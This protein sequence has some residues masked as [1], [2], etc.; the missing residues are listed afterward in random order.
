[1][2]LGGP[3]LFVP[4]TQEPRFAKAHSAGASQ[5]IVDWEDAV[6]PRDKDGARET[7]ARWLASSPPTWVRVN[8]ASTEWYESDVAALERLDGLAGVVVPKAEDPGVLQHVGDRLARPVMA[9]VE[10]ARGLDRARE[11]ART[12]AVVAIA[13][14]SLDFAHDL[15]CA[16]TDRALLAARSEL[17]LAS[18]LGDLVPPIDGVTANVQ[19]PQAA[20]ADARLARELG[21][22]GKLCIHPRQIA[23]VRTAFAPSESELSW[24]RAVLAAAADTR[25]AVLG[26]DGE[27]IDR[28]VIER[29]H[30]ILESTI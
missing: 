17:V 25:G 2:R 19:D 13:F 1:M 24:A 28:P 14:G 27:M 9:L 21:F 30:A 11:L 4:G 3:W 8:A 15:H 29:A 26:P 16:P 10:S 23:P 20:A 6:D 5:V 12:P 22:G 18:R 7:T